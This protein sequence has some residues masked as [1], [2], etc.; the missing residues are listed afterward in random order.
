MSFRGNENL[1]IHGDGTLVV[2]AP[3]LALAGW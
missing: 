1:G 3:V 2:S